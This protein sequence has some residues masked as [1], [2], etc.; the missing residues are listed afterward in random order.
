MTSDRGT[1]NYFSIVRPIFMDA[2]APAPNR[3]KVYKKK[4]LQISN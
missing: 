3:P 1:G 4:P 2:A